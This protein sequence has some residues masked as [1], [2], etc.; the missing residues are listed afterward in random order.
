MKGIVGKSVGARFRTLPIDIAK[1]RH[2]I[3]MA[4]L[5]A[6]A[7]VAT[8]HGAANASTSDTTFTAISTQVTNYV[9]G[10][11]GKTIMTAMV[12]AGIGLGIT[13]QSLVP[14]AV[15]IGGGIGLYNTP[16]ILGTIFSATL[17][18]VQSVA[19]NID[20]VHVASALN[21]VS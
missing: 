10:G 7:V 6:L 11:L 20:L 9:Q 21:L 2:R 15:G 19:Q 17:P 4:A 18:G 14:F 1:T 3:A 16:T 12:I 8:F 13:R 5:M